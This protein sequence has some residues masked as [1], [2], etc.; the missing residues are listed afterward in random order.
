MQASAREQW[1]LDQFSLG[2][3]DVE[4][5]RHVQFGHPPDLNAAISLAIEFEAF[6]SGTNDKLKKPANKGEISTLKVGN[7]NDPDSKQGEF[8]KADGPRDRQNNSESNGFKQNIEC[9]YCKKKGHM[10]RDCFKLKNKHEREENSEKDEST[11]KKERK[12]LGN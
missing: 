10:L 4:I 7:P 6:K 8:R 3:S 2:L 9:F 5:R 1:V 12:N 11:P